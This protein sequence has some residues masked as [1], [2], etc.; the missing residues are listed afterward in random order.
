MTQTTTIAPRRIALGSAAIVLGGVLVIVGSLLTWARASMIL[1][2]PITFAGT[3]VP[4]GKVTAALGL[5]IAMGGVAVHLPQRRRA[6]RIATRLSSLA[7]LF[8]GVL[9]V[10]DLSNLTERA[11]AANVYVTRVAVGEGLYVLLVGALLGGVGLFLDGRSTSVT[12]ELG[13]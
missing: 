6:A 8:V 5:V 7:V 12:E 1:S 3:A 10:I 4:I 9:N 11:H 13:R 2:S